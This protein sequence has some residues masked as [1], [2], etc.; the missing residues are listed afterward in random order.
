MSFEYTFKPKNVTRKLLAPLPKRESDVLI[1]RFG[2]GTSIKR[3]TL[4]SIGSR[5]H[6]TRERVRQ[7]ESKAIE[8]IRESRSYQECEDAF[9]E[10][11]GIINDLGGIVPEQELL[12]S[13]SS[14]ES[15]QNHIHF[16]LVVGSQFFRSKEDSDF[17]NRWHA[18]QTVAD[19]VHGALKSIHR[20]LS[21][22][23]LITEDKLVSLFSKELKR[24]DQM[25]AKKEVIDRWLSLSRKIGKNPLGEWGRTDSAGV[26]VKNMRDMAYLALKRHGSPM[27]FAE[28]AHSISQ[29]FNKK[30]HEATCHNELIKDK[31][32]VLVGRGLYALSEWGYSKG[33][34]KDVIRDILKREGALSKKDIIEKV[35]RER[36]V[37][38]GTILVNLQ[39]T[40]MFT[41]Q[42]DGTF[43]AR[44]NA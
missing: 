1:G 18:D 39:D 7:I 9:R 4:E 27:H 22:E 26:R 30:A 38:E 17:V 14:N 33:V 6:I 35:K 21:P 31:R 2:L 34:V 15:I 11:S 32:F 29:L 13:I 37:K 28:V 3:D 25:N 42:S 40:K 36:Y 44:E 24:L 5:F 19:S 12:E 41:R 16:M 43:V 20:T 8:S 23:E 10:L